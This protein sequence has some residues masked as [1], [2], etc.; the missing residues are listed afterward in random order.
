MAKRAQKTDEQKGDEVLRRLLNTPPEPKTGKTVLP[1]SDGH[2]E[3][4]QPL[5][6]RAH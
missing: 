5:E 6:N 3:N 2:S 1:E 4:A